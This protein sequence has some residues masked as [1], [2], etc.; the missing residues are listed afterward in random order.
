MKTRIKRVL[1]QMA[2]IAIVAAVFAVTVP[3]DVRATIINVPAD[4]PTIQAAINGAGSGDTVHV[5]PGTYYER[6]TLKSGVIVQGAGAGVTTID[7]VW[8]GPV[9]TASNVDSTAVLDGFTITRGIS[10][11]GGGMYNESGS[12]TV[13]NCTFSG[14]KAGRWGGGMFNAGSPTV[15]NCTFSGNYAWLSGGGMF[16]AGSPTVTNC[17]FSGNSASGG[18]GMTNMNSSNPTLTN[19]TFSGNSGWGGA[20]M[21]NNNSSPTL[22]NCIFSGNQAADQ[23]GGIANYTN[24]RPT[25]TNCTFSGNSA[26]FG[27]GIW[28]NR[29]SSST[30]T[31]C[32]LWGDTAR[33]AGPEIFLGVIY[34]HYST[35]TV[36]Y[37]DV[38]GGETAVYLQSSGCTLNWGDGNIDADPL[39]ADANLRLSAGSPC[40]NAGSNAALPPDTADLD[41]DGDTAEPIP[42]D[43][44]SNARISNGIVDMGAYECQVPS[45]RP[46]VADAGP[47]QTVEQDSHAGASVTVDGSG[48][49]DPDNDS[50]TYSW[51]WDGGSATGVSPTVVLPLGTTT[52]TLVVND[53]KVDSDP[54]TVDITVVDTTPPTI[55]SVSASPDVLWPPNH[56]MVEVTVTVVATDICDAAPVC[57]ILGVNS[58]EPINGPGD[59]NTEPDWEYTDEPLVVLLRAESAGVGTGRVYSILVECMDASGN[60]T[61]AMVEVIV[62]HDQGKG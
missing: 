52:I 11:Y 30:L 18:A 1:S 39:F 44:D 19:C 32:I 17:T 3:R 34:I 15:T 22:T 14:N 49:Y 20:G 33:T 53:G 36:S 23:G 24:S 57:W 47:D 38:D 40:I 62:P 5:A 54:D 29:G 6:I 8:S 12:P 21:Y 46:P 48:S 41:G 35:L 45:N 61:T 26:R 51:T 43:L 25:L 7:S 58:N 50:L 9:V 2:S 37:S 60:I 27:G 56:K 31:N 4:Y 28:N 42:L 13:T 59:G 55:H 16:N 10:N